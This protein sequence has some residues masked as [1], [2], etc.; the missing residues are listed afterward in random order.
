[1]RTPA[2]CCLMSLGSLRS[3]CMCTVGHTGVERLWGSY[4]YRE[5]CR[6]QYCQSFRAQTTLTRPLD[7]SLR[8]AKLTALVFCITNFDNWEPDPFFCASQSHEA[9]LL[10]LQ[11]DH[12]AQKASLEETQHKS[13]SIKRFLD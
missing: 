1:M 6:Q 10:S 11:V 9:T 12:C 4:R 7:L 3:F 13:R 5:A 2:T 8:N